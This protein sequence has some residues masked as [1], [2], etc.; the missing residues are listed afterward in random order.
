MIRVYSAE[1]IVDAQIVADALIAA[2]LQAHI[3]GSYLSGAVGEL[4]PNTLVTVWITDETAS[5]QARKIVE[6]FERDLIKRGNHSDSVLSCSRCQEISSA[7][8]THC[9][10]C[11]NLLPDPL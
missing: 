11:G 10:Q 7:N 4:P 1:S 5:D 3:Q 6:A 9:W 8:F 2:G